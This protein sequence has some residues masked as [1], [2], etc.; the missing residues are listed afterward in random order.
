MVAN[1]RAIAPRKRTLLVIHGCFVAALAASSLA[2]G[3]TPPS[4]NSGTD[5]S[6]PREHHR[7]PPPEALDACANK[8]M[9]DTCSFTSPRGAVEGTCRAPEGKPLACRPANGRQPPPDQK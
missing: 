4:D 1:S 6:P 2:W 5:Q 7:G 3:Q 8:K 9:A